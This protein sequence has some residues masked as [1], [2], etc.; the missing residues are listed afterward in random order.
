MP[1]ADF[2]DLGRRIRDFSP[3]SVVSISLWGEPACHPEIWAILEG[4]RQC[5]P[6]QLYVETA[7]I[8]WN[9]ERLEAF[10]QSGAHDHV[11]W[12][13]SLDAMEATTY[14]TM[15]GE[16]WAEALAGAHL[17]TR[18]FPQTAYIQAVRCKLNEE[19]MQAHYQYWK[20]LG[21]KQIIQKYDHFSFRLPDRR[22]SDIAPLDRLA[23]WHLKRDMAILLDGTVALC[24]QD[25]P[26]QTGD[27]LQFVAG[28]AFADELPLIWKRLELPYLQHLGCEYPGICEKC[29]EYYTFNY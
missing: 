15:R 24:R 20:K 26:V 9:T 25:V 17:F 18:L 1:A 5:A 12:I 2:L 4:F 6:L 19:P 28:N 23:C 22:L 29:D 7:G 11:T 8:G 16:G 13:V 10:A 21:F 3:E 27:K 14:A